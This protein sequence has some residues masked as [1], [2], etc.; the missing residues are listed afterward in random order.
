MKRQRL[1]RRVAL[2]HRQLAGRRDRARQREAPLAVGGDCLERVG[3]P[4]GVEGHGRREERLE[5]RAELARQRVPGARGQLEQPADPVAP[6][7]QDIER[8]GVVGGV[9]EDVGDR[10]Q[11]AGDQLGERRVEQRRHVEQVHEA[12]AGREHARDLGDRAALA[13]APPAWIASK[14][15]SPSTPPHA[16]S[17][18]G[19]RSAR[20]AATRASGARPRR[21]ASARRDGSVWS[22]RAAIAG[23][24]QAAQRAGAGADLQQRAPSP[25]GNRASVSPTIAASRSA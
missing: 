25:S 1:E 12:P 5:E 11:T 14:T 2:L 17:A 13:S 18:T 3:G 21:S 24:S 7:Q 8:P 15:H 16:R 9:A 10:H 23:G 22:A 6:Q 20:A 4:L 19:R